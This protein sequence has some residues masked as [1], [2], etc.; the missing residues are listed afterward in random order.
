MRNMESLYQMTTNQSDYIN[1][2]VE[3]NISWRCDNS[4]ALVSDVGLENWKNRLYEVS[5]RRCAYLTKSLR[6]IGAEIKDIPSFDG[7]VDV[8]DFLYQFE[9]E[10]PHEQRMLAIDLAVRATPAIWWHAHK[11]HIASWDDFKRLTTIRFSND[12]ECLQKKYTGESD[13]RSHIQSCEQN[14]SDIPEDEWV[15]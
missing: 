5:A 10:I 13:P 12:K 14:W 4:C 8:N 15:H 7:L 3:G 9:Q 1:P 6:W 11:Q 2:T